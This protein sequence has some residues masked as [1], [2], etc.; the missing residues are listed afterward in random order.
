MD[1]TLLPYKKNGAFLGMK[2]KRMMAGTLSSAA[3]GVPALV[4]DTNKLDFFSE[5]VFI[6]AENT[7]LIDQD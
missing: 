3:A 7:G 4:F 2:K 1:D 5:E 6:N